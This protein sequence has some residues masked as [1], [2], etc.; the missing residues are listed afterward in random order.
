MRQR[1][2]RRTGGHMAKL[3]AMSDKSNTTVGQRQ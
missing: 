2:R 1:R 3:N